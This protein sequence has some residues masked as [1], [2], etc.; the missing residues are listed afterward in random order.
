[1]KTKLIWGLI[2]GAGLLISS[3]AS[4]HKGHDEALRIALEG[5]E[6]MLQYS[7]DTHQLVAFD[8]NA[9]GRLSVREYRRQAPAIGDWIDTHLA[10]IDHRGGMIPAY[11]SDNPVTHFHDLSDDDTVSKIRVIRRYKVPSDASALRLKFVLH[12]ADE[13]HLVP[14]AIVSGE[15]VRHGTLTHQAAQLLQVR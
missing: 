11:F 9:D 2:G 4:A 14:Y 6:V 15:K 3:L 12:D 8:S 10:L 5:E 7:L 13:Q 1:M